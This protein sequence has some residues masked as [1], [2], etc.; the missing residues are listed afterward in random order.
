M[1]PH[2]KS[3]AKSVIAVIPARAASVRL[4]GKLLR[5]IAGKPLIVHTFERAKAA[6]SVSRVI[7]ATD[8]EAIRGAVIAAGGEAQMTSPEHSSGSDRVAEVAAGLPEGSIIV[9]VQGDE[10]LI[11]PE[12][13]DAAVE[14]ILETEESDIVSVYET[15]ESASEV[16]DPN[17]VKVVTDK[18]GHALYFSRSPMPWP[19]DAS[20][21]HG[22]DA[23]RAVE[24][25]PELLAHFKKHTGL[26][27]YRR[28]YLL[29]FSKMPQTPLEKFEMLEQ[30]R[31]LENGARIKLVKAAANSIGVDTEDDLEK[32][33]RVLET[34][35]SR[36][37][38]I[39]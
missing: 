29:E 23:I 21:K 36:S 37:V 1:E 10:P 39:N 34:Q 26:Y 33:R 30:L 6:K 38:I 35:V 13:I 28:E 24:S 27:V 3:P 11:A 20:L 22:G 18:T 14:A 31:A 2:G 25:E 32:V 9:N 17:N 7:V 19:R 16:F 15:F 8:D 4:P 12:T 5:E